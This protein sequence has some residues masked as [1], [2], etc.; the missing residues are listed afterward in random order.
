MTPPAR[1]LRRLA[2]LA[3][4]LGSAAHAAGVPTLQE[5]A[6]TARQH[7]LIGVA[8]SASEGTVTAA[9]LRNRP[10]LRPAEALE[11]VPG[12]IVT[13]HSGDGKANQYFL[14]GFNLDHGSDFATH[15]MGMPVN[16]ASHAHG[17]GYMDLNFLMPE[18]VQGIAYRKGVYAAEDG[19]FA[20]TGSARID[21]RRRLEHPFAQVGLGQNG[22]R[23]LLAAGSQALGGDGDGRQLLVATELMGY[24]GPWAQ[25]ENLQRRNLLLRLSDG[26]PSRGYAIT[27]M[28]YSADWTA[29]EHVPER[30]IRS[31]EIGRYGALSPRDGGRTRRNSL[32]AEW[33]R[34]GDGDAT[35]ASAYVIDYGLNLYSAPSG[36]ISGLQGDQHEQADSRLVWGGEARHS[37]QPVAALRDTEFSA[38][39]RLRQDRIGRVGLFTTEGRARTGTVREDRIT[40]TALAAYVEARTQWLPWLRSTAALRRDEIAADVTA[41]GGQYNLGNGGSVRGGQTSPRLGLVF[42]PFIPVYGLGA[43]AILL[44][45]PLVRDSLPLLFPAAALVCTAVEYVTGLFYEKVF[46]VSFWDYSHLPL[47]LGGRV[48]LLFA[49]FW[50]VL[51][52]LVLHVIHPAAA[53]LAALPPG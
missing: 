21:Y 29:T 33:A 27:A 51:A 19:D 49:L 38:G 18:L 15:V 40:E 4:T 14:R 26:S 52:L 42:G 13:Q 8:D 30:A 25:P 2:L 16:M 45:P 39:A 46:R 6:V 37:W 24:D 53:W 5:V 43:L 44:L 17:Q 32:S 10:L 50:G 7:E 1:R 20:T 48:C 11:T 23:R 35:R 31:G 12:L 34:L 28:S 47:N 36:Y 9:Q 41:L 3:S 22:Y